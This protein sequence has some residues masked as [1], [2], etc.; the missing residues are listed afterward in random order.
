MAKKQSIAVGRRGFLKTVLVTAGG[1]SVGASLPGCDDEACPVSENASDVFPQSVASGDPRTDSIVL[2]T[3]LAAPGEVSLEVYE[4]EACAGP[5]L[6]L[7]ADTFTASADHDNCV[8]VKVDGLSAG[9]TYSYQFVSG[10]T[11]SRVGRF[12]TAAAPGSADE[13]KFAVL[14]C[15]DYTG[16][17]YNTLL[18]LLDEDQDDIAFVVHLGDYVYETTGDPQFMMTGSD[19]SIT[20][21]DEAGAID[22]GDGD[23]AAASV[24]NYR[25]L[26]KTYRT[27]PVL[28][29]VHEK[30][31]FVVT[32]DDHEFSD[33][34]W[35]DHGTY[36]DGVEVEQSAQ[37][38]QNAEQVWL[39]YQPVALEG[40]GAGQL[41]P[42]TSQLFP[43]TRIYRDFRFGDTV[44]LALTDYRS[45]RPDH[46]VPEDAFPGQ[47]VVDQAGVI[48]TLTALEAAGQFTL[49]EG[50]PDITTFVT[51]GAGGLVGPYYDFTDED[52]LTAMR[53][54]A[55]TQIA[56][57]GYVADGVD[58]TR[59]AALAA[60]GVS[61]NVDGE[62]FNAFIATAAETTPELADLAIDLET[63][64]PAGF[65]IAWARTGKT[66]LTGQLGARYLVVKF[67][68]DLI[69]AYRTFVQS[70]TAHDDVFGATQEAW[71]RDRV[72][73]NADVTWNVIGNSVSNTS[74]ILDLEAFGDALPA[75]LPAT[76]YYLNCDQWDG[77]TVR[78]SQLFSSLYTPNNAVLIA[79]DIHASYAT[80]YPGD[81][82]GNHAVEFTGSSVSSGTFV[83]LLRSTAEASPSLTG[84]PIVDQVINS[85]DGLLQAGFDRLRFARSNENGVLVITARSTEMLADYFTLP[86]D[87]VTES[88]YDRR[89]ELTFNT[90][91]MRVPKEDGRNGA[92]EFVG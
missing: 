81:A 92:M 29:Q 88:Y 19:R 12:R 73:E 71:L 58:A 85:V 77:F 26:Y 51:S 67:T 21:S 30:F 80:D 39:E 69:Q 44:H 75:G 70:D 55:L 17:Y 24:S 8:R 38:K 76:Q 83:E 22:R 64:T 10:D 57:A 20:F 41:T 53:A 68:Y 32:W 6:S 40:E 54:A 27:D 47:V 48:A 45:F 25:E 1:V 52:A 34:S 42:Q 36:T 16:R 2:W 86:G 37:R 61:G 65:G 50:V 74:L 13:V 78:R 31:P 62:I 43:N 9:R 79:G 56:T 35:A 15:Q 89:A 90:Q 66:G 14:S 7:S 5:R 84:S 91:Q 3:R 18:R 59:A 11:R 46:P 63:E 23:F 72:E 4:D 82:E 60:E 28:Q 33:D 49:P 87:V